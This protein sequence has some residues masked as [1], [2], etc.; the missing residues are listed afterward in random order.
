MRDQKGTWVNFQVDATTNRWLTESAQRSGRQKRSEAA[1]R[2]KDH[3]ERFQSIA[4]I[5]E[6][7]DRDKTKQERDA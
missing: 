7:V 1:L 5:G 3:L 2:L 4:A 6:T